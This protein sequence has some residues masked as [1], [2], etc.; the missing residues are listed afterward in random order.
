MLEVVVVA[1][2]DVCVPEEPVPPEPPQAATATTMA[3]NPVS[4]NMDFCY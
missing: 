4:F 3:S 2:E 1:A